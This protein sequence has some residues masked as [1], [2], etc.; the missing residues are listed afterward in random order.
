MLVRVDAKAVVEGPLAFTELHLYFHNPEPRRREGTFAITLPAHSAVSRFAMERDGTWQEAEVV[1][2]VLARR[3]YEDFLH[4]RQDPALLE[5]AAGNQFSARVFPI[6]AKGDKHLVIAY[7][8]E[9]TEAYTLPMRGLA[10]TERID[11]RVDATGADKAQELHER[12]WQPD[13]DFVAGAKGP[14]AIA[15]G[16]LVAGSFEITAPGTAEPIE[17]ITL[18]VDTSASRVL[19]FAG[20]L[21]RVHTL[22]TGLRVRYGDALALQVVA[23]DQETRSVFSGHAADFGEAQLSTLRDREAAGASDLGQALDTIASTTHRHIVVVSDGVITAGKQPRELADTIGKLDADRL[24]IVLSGGIRDDRLAASLVR[25]LA[26]NG[27]VFDLDRD[28]ADVI[29]GIGES[30]AHDVKLD[31]R[32]ATWV[33]PRTLRSARAGT[34]VIFYARMAQ[35]AQLLD[36]A[37]GTQHVSVPVVAAPPALL[38]RAIAQADIS[39][40]EGQ[41]ELAPPSSEEASQLRETIRKASVAARVISSQT[42]ML[43]LESDSDYERYG[44]ARTALADIL[45]VGPRGLEQSHRTFVASVPPP[46]EVPDETRPGTAM[47]LDEGKMGRSDRIHEG[48][49]ALT[50]DQD[51]SSGFDA[52]VYGGL[53]GNDTGFGE[54]RVG[55]GAGSGAGY[56]VGR[57]GMIAAGR[58]GN[59]PVAFVGNPVSSAGLDKAIVRRY[60]KRNIQKIQYC[61]E[62]QLLAHPGIEGTV[63]ARF[64]ITASGTVKGATATGFDRD[65]ASC[66]ASVIENIQFPRPTTDFVGVSCPFAF[67]ISGDGGA[68]RQF[69]AM[70]PRATSNA[71][72][73]AA[74]SNDHTPALTGRLADVMDALAHDRIDQ[75]YTTAKAWHDETPGDVLALIALGEVFEARNEPAAAARM[76]GSIIDLYPARA[77]FRRF[78]GERLERIGTSDEGTAR[79][80]AI[81]TYRR[82]VAD[83]PDHATGHRL[84]AYALL[85]AGDYAGAFTAILAGIDQRYPANRFLGVEHVFRDDAGMIAAAYLAHGG[86][87]KLISDEL[88]KRSLSLATEPSTRFLVYWETDANDVDFHIEDKRGDNAWYAHP[89][90]ASGGELYAD[91]TTGYG[92]ECFAIPGAASAGPY[93]LSLHYYSQGP[94][95]YGM[96]LVQIQRYDGKGGLVFEDRPYVIMTDHAYVSLGAAR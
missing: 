63:A 77:D 66:V 86:T 79:K 8:Q 43:V 12:N 22:V 32:G 53:L 91:V 62:R 48:F 96:G 76:Y 52:E 9:L 37:I 34:P 1:E 94:M 25:I 75:A 23:F 57:Y 7:S 42:A 51:F 90:L 80:L 3:A 59:A 78:A 87:S 93:K 31:V 40:L 56:G 44:I 24:D 27:D 65:V 89:A 61:Y 20:Y 83:R 36:I 88:A 2:K 29:A 45:V 14:A 67:R 84:L 81:D 10:K 18:L 33:Y 58:R 50:S 16:A 4:R 28:L 55:F 35:P 5:Q 49:A 15:S 60:I 41:L 30:V 19:D 21:D 85:R 69:P 70:P 64:T 71:S 38:E 17:A 6:E 82:A 73:M 72:P 54:G 68:P 47:A 95:G 11:V 74:P 13:R 92:P 39:E 46:S 26:H